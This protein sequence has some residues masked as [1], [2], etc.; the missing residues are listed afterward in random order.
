MSGVT[1]RVPA[2]AARTRPVTSCRSCGEPIEGRLVNCGYSIVRRDDGSYWSGE[3]VLH[4]ECYLEWK[5]NAQLPNP[6]EAWWWRRC[7][8]CRRDFWKPN[9][10]DA[11]VCSD[12]CRKSS[13]RG[14]FLPTLTKKCAQCDRYFEPARTDSRYCSSACR[15]AAYRARRTP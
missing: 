2:R 15:Q 4:P 1:D 6:E 8:V 9:Y 12:T 3:A 7:L 5:P 11:S 10:R 14:W 13:A